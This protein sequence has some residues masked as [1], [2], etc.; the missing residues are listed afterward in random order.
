MSSINARESDSDAGGERPCPP[1]G[2]GCREKPPAASRRP[3]DA[4]CCA[5]PAC[6][7][8]RRPS[9]SSTADGPRPVRRVVGSCGP[10]LRLSGLG[11]ASSA[12]QARGPVQGAAGVRGLVA[13]PPPAGP[14][15]AA[16]RSRLD[17]GGR[18]PQ[19]QSGQDA[20]ASQ[21][22]SARPAKAIAPAHPQAQSPLV[23]PSPAAPV[24]EFDRRL[25]ETL[26]IPMYT[27]RRQRQPRAQSPGAGAT[28]Q[29][30]LGS[31]PNSCY[32]AVTLN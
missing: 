31:G 13:R 5:E 21:A 9:S 29:P 26:A 17:G 4:A 11:T 19:R 15:C 3:A 2:C 8:G 23:H 32:S 18:G 1:P 24:P 30:A 22:A 7:G 20:P 12:G 14:S 27:S 6:A 10:A 16:A 25:T 28:M